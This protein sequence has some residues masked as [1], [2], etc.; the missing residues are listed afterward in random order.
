MYANKFQLGWK[1]QEMTEQQH[2]GFDLK[3]G[4]VHKKFK[5][6]KKTVKGPEKTMFLYG[7]LSGDQPN[8]C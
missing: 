1:F 7:L 4:Y 8:I 3:L 2:T 6:D 5:S